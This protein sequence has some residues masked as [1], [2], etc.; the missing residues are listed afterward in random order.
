MGHPLEI[1]RLKHVVEKVAERA[2]RWR[3]EA[4]WELCNKLFMYCRAWEKHL[5]LLLCSLSQTKD[6]DSSDESF[7]EGREELRVT[8]TQIDQGK[9]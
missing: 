1:G 2:E 9:D 7:N 4:C 6:M 3:T 8:L 5:N